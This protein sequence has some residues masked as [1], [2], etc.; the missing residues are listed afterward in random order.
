M[1]IPALVLA[2][3]LPVIMVFSAALVIQAGIRMDSAEDLKT[4]DYFQTSAFADNFYSKISTILSGISAREI[5]DKTN[6]YAYIDLGELYNGDS[7]SFKNTSGLAYSFNDLKEWSSQTI[8]S[9][10]DWIVLGLTTPEGETKYMYYSDFKKALE[11]GTL[12]LNANSGALK[13]E[14]ISQKDWTERILSSLSAE[15]ADGGIQSQEPLKNITDKNGNVVYTDVADMLTPILEIPCA[16]EG[17]D[18]LLDYMNSTSSKTRNFK[19]NLNDAFEQLDNARDLFSSWTEA[20]QTLEEYSSD[21]SNIH[22]AYTDNTSQK[23]FTN[24]DAAY[25]SDLTDISGFS[26]K[27][28]YVF[29][30]VNEAATDEKNARNGLMNLNLS[31][32]ATPS[33]G[34]WID[35]LRNST[36]DE[37]CSFLAWIDDTSLPVQDS[38]KTDRQHFLTYHT[39]FIP[40]AVITA[41]SFLLFIIDFIWLTVHTGRRN[42]DSGNTDTAQPELNFF[43]KIY[44]E[45]AAGLV[46]IPALGVLT[47]GLSMQAST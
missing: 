5:L 2:L 35:L 14:G 13:Y 17:Y 7:L 25:T 15:Y 16:P 26:D 42:S 43:D 18:S 21:N 27:K 39:L 30:S 3:I 47:A 19:G 45:A 6:E 24:T 29:L 8:H 41:I 32:A 20:A 46:C 1:R 34:N 37:N 31:A 28:P 4:K 40:A 22:Y 33:V 9:N 38:I 23:I 36:Y 11:D 44:T 10:D 12:Q